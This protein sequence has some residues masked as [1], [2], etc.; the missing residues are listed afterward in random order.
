VILRQ[1]TVKCGHFESHPESRPRLSAS[2]SQPEEVVMFVIAGATGHTGSIAAETLLGA[3]K[4]V[5]AVVRNVARA[6]AA[7]AERL[8][9][10][11][12]DTFVADLADQAAL[13]RARTGS[14]RPLLGTPAGRRS[15]RPP[16][17]RSSVNS[18]LPVWFPSCALHAGGR[19]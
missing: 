6:E 8:R 17:A 4:K 5:R 3:G 2:S 7:K 11:G 1:V 15:S 10:R 14:S 16:C 19:L 18:A 13:G 9:A 12:A